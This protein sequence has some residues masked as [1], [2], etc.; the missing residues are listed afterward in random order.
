MQNE[1]KTNIVKGALIGFA[2]GI[3]QARIAVEDTIGKGSN[4]VIEKEDYPGYILTKDAYSIIQSIKLGD[5][6]EQKAIDM[7]RDATDSQ[8]KRSKDGRTAMT[9][10]CDSIL[11]ESIKSG[12][13]PAIINK[14]INELLPKIEDLILKQKKPIS[15][16][17]INIVAKTASDSKRI[18]DLLG[19][20][21]KKIGK[22]G[23]IHVEGSG[24]W[25]DCIEYTDGIKFNDAG[26]ISPYMGD[27]KSKKAVYENPIILVTKRKIEKEADISALID[28][29]IR[30]N[31]ALVIFCDDMDSNLASNI[32]ATHRAKVAKILIIKA[33]IL[34]KNFIYEDFAKVTGATVIEESS[35]VN[36]KNLAFEHLGTC[37]KIVTDAEETVIVSN[38]DYSAHI[39]DLKAK[40][41]NDSLLRLSWLASKTAILKLGANN[42]GELS[43]TRLKTEDA[44]HSSKLAL[45]DG[46]VKGGG[47]CLYKV[48]LEMPDTIGGRILSRA[49]KAPLEQIMINAGS[50][51]ELH[52]FETYVDMEDLLDSAGV[53][54]NSV[55]NAIAL[56]ST[57]LT[58]K[59]YISIPP[60]SQEQLM[61]ET[62]V[63]QQR[64][65]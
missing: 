55:R 37:S 2:N 35:G 53:V 44:V 54:R 15:E 50:K 58:S 42:E 9:L 46:V 51:M 26:F 17:K 48:S 16:D 33:P 63:A 34:W 60:K 14:E 22:E 29:S 32:V 64:R 8:N 47:L 41:D 11:Q 21:Y 3:H 40:G 4:A 65:F 12:E 28:N 1:Y 61:H 52:D 19:E 38:I 56:A 7:L 39:N 31:K 59:I 6:T 5:K 36:F 62:L 43:F 18:G 27:E 57:P 10:I 45:L 49:L 23:I 20:I 25:N 13:N 24:T 30:Q